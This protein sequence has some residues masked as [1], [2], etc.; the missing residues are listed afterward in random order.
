M[1]LW[2]AREP[3]SRGRSGEIPEPTVRVRMKEE[4]F[5][6]TV[7]FLVDE[8]QHIA[9]PHLSRAYKLALLG[10][11][12]TSPNPMVGC[13][14]VRDGEVVGE[15]YHAAAG[16]PHAEAM[17]LGQA[18]AL[19][20][21]ATAYV[22][23]EPC[24]HVGRTPSCAAALVDAGVTAVVIGMPDPNP[25]AAGGASVLAASGV[26]VSFIEDPSPFRSL[27]EEWLHHLE[28]VRPFVRVKV[29]LSIDGKPTSAVGIRC[30]I[31][32]EG[33]RRITMALRERAD[34]VLVGAATALIDDPVLTVRDADGAPCERQPVRA[35]LG[36]RAIP[37]VA[38][39]DDG[40][41]LVTALLEQTA[42]DPHLPE[43]VRILRY[44][45]GDGV[46]GAIEALGEAGICSLLVEAGPRLFSSLW[47]AD[48]I[49]ELVV[50]QAGGVLGAH[51]PS[52]FTGESGCEPNRL[53]LR[54]RPVES[55]VFFEDVVTI[56]RP[57][58]D[59]SSE[60]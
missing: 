53:S 10:A 46:K 59:G 55:S 19:A 34:A 16:M 3:R 22:T 28:H 58:A 4:R 17:A 36:R 48:M 57:C 30:A 35:I 12:A 56:W 6:R 42:P 8:S 41:G 60:G 15:G 5:L 39:L 31:T 7:R 26:A 20:E 32:A 44:P 43:H 21:G 54:M 51:T 29:A 14:L 23:L 45:D 49:D 9:D 27:N 50:I 33:G 38:M 18:G 25:V 52:L 1:I 37:Q 13:V 40:L 47:D 2:E 11:G 24:A